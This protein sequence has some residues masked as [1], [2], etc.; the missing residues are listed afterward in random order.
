M[1]WFGYPII[2]GL[3][4]GMRG[5]VTKAVARGETPLHWVLRPGYVDKLTV[6][7]RH[8]LGYRPIPGHRHSTPEAFFGVPIKIC[9]LDTP[10][11]LVTSAG[12]VL[13]SPTQSSASPRG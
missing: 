3:R 4:D 7:T 12:K 2:M 1:F 11:H 6:E 13:L 5:L 10:N 8:V 9:G